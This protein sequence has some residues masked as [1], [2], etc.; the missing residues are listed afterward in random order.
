MENVVVSVF[1]VES[2]AFQAFSE[3]RQA[4]SGE[5][6]VVAEAAL[7][8]NEGGRISAVDGFAIDGKTVDDTANGM[9]IGSLV[10]I[11]GGPFGVLLGASFGALTGSMMDTADAQNTLSAVEI[12]A[13]KLFEGEIAVV[14]LVQEEEPAFDVAFQKY[15]TTTIR[16]DAADIAEEV[17][18]ATELQIEMANEMRAKMRAERK[19][20]RIARREERRA[21]IKS[22]FEDYSELTYKAMGYSK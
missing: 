9:V 7:L 14:A 4:P 1:A 15:E 5:G 18:R 6:Y 20:E 12:V 2:E 10:G 19:E 11:I 21:A 17:D 16:Y 3:L 22:N 13:N 8:K